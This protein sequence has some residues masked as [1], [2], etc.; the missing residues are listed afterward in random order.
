MSL[1]NLQNCIRL[2]SAHRWIQESVNPHAG[3]SPRVGLLGI[4]EL[5]QFE[6][7]FKEF[8]LVMYE[9]RKNLPI[10]GAERQLIWSVDTS[11]IVLMVE[12]LKEDQGLEGQI[13]SRIFLH[14]QTASQSE[15]H[16]GMCGP[17]SPLPTPGTAQY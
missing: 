14:L 3:Q 1:F 5:G 6:F 10:S 4:D 7:T 13:G 17:L 11:W 12:N 8:E 2:F 16:L 9:R 15:K